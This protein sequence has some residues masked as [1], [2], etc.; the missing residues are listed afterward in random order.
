MERGYNVCAACLNFVVVSNL[1]CFAQ[2]DLKKISSIVQKR[3]ERGDEDEEKEE[4]GQGSKKRQKKGGSKKKAANT[5][6]DVA[7]SVPLA[8]VPVEEVSL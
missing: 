7:D 3:S 5:D 2:V 1:L 4:E 8:P 6:P